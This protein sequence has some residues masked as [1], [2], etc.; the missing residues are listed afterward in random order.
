MLKSDVKIPSDK[1]PIDL[2]PGDICDDG[3]LIGY[4]SDTGK[5]FYLPFEDFTRHGFVLGQSGVGKTVLGRLLLFQQ[6][7]RGGGLLFIDGKMNIEEL[8]TIYRYC[9][10][11][12]REKDLLVINPGDPSMSNTYNPIMEGDPDEIAARILSL[13]PDTSASPGAD[14]YRQAANQ[15]LVTIVAALKAAGLAFNF[16]DLTILLINQKAMLDLERRV[17]AGHPARTNLSLFLDQFRIVDREGKATIDM[18]RMKETFGGIAGRMY[19]FGTN[20]FGQVMNTYSPECDIYTSMTKNKIIYIMLP[21]MGKNEAAQNLG[22]MIIGDMRTA[23]SWVQ[24]LPD[25]EKPWPPYLIFMD[26]AGS[27]SAASMSRIFEQARSAQI[28]LV[29]AVQTIANLQAVSEELAEMVI[30]NTW[31][32]FIFKIGTQESALAA[33]ELIGMQK[34]VVRS[35]GST[36]A[37]SESAMF[38]APGDPNYSVGEGGGMSY[39][40]REQED[41]R[42]SA[43]TIK[44]LDKGECIVV[45]GGSNIYHLKIPMIKMTPEF[46][47]ANDKVILNKFPVRAKKAIDLFSRADQLLSTGD[48]QD[49][50]TQVGKENE[51]MRKS[52][53]GRSAPGQ[54][55]APATKGGNGFQGRR[56][57]KDE[58]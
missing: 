22:K 36:S 30:G 53:K 43:D 38:V 37:K 35:M 28:A 42:V 19:M 1:P 6:I 29:P 16:I 34:G 12:G 21:T 13:I 2:N 18:K 49:I 41:Y 3:I 33:A 51:D 56:I 24:K 27:Y 54:K 57:F 11:A 46:I 8:E 45:Y 17:P 47:K 10:W 31:T 48:M 40:E 14:H 32:K 4:C 39:T 55:G 23:V 52:D 26:E 58:A 44:A 20:Q 50:T 9:K 25:K 15:G 7:L 5:P